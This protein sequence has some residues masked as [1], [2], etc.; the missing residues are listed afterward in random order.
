MNS[1]SNFQPMS[2]QELQAL[3]EK[4]KDWASDERDE[5][6]KSTKMP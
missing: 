6:C 2:A 4:V 5:R 3:R 1:T